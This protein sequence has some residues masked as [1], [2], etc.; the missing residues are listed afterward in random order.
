VLGGVETALVTLFRSLDRERF[1]VSFVLTGFGPFYDR[2]VEMGAR[3]L[4]YSCRGRY[5]FSWHR[6]LAEHLHTTHYD[7][8]HLTAPLPNV[9]IL[10][11]HGI[12]VVGRLNFPRMKH[13]WYP[14]RFTPLDR[15]CSR[16]FDGYVAVSQAIVRQFI[17]RGYDPVKLHLIHNGVE[18]S[19]RPVSSL[20]EELN[21][22][23][24][25]R[26]V[27]TIGRM[28]HEKGM[29]QFLR[30]AR[31]IARS[32]DVTF[33]IAGD[34]DKCEELM[35]LAGELGLRERVR[36]LGFRRD[37]LNVLAGF[38]VLLYLSRWEAFSNTIIEAMS[39]GVPVVATAVGGNIEALSGVGEGILVPKGDISAAVSATQRLLHDADHRAA[40]TTAMAKAV[41]AFSVEAM[42]QRHEALFESLAQSA[43]N[44]RRF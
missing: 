43:F 25:H 16:F 4:A 22:P 34:G 30:V 36:F 28:R 26:I 24:H 9:W 15:F 27:G 41:T 14:M 6:F 12:K 17:E 35:A 29:D 8:A 20:R 19:A 10:K 5:S 1:E 21:I 11:R 13:G 33:V 3:P 32:P 40:V 7:V 23:A 31:E 37:P 2:L 38:D 18:F 39:I 44:E 42:V